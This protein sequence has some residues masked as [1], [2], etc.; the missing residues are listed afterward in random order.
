MQAREVVAA[1]AAAVGVAEM[2]AAVHALTVMMA[3]SPHARIAAVLTARAGEVVG[4]DCS[5]CSH[6]L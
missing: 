5:G 4:G 6:E 1:V 2:A 3:G